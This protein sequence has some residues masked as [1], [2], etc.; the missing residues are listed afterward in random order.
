MSG[1]VAFYVVSFKYYNNKNNVS[2]RNLKNH[3]F[4]LTNFMVL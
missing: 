1:F 3:F 4:G 2:C